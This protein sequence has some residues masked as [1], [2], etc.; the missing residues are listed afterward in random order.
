MK[1]HAFPKTPNPKLQVPEKLQTPS[2]NPGL[3]YRHRFTSEWIP[4]SRCIGAWSLELLWSLGLGAWSF[5][6]FLWSLVLGPWS[7][8]ASANPIGPVVT[9]GTASFT[10]KGTHFTVNTSDR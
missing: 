4:G 5:R 9:Q 2:S 3:H 6:V 8:R 1:P 7:F 10:T